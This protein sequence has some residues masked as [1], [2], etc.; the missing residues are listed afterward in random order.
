MKARSL[1]S[2][3]LLVVLIGSIFLGYRVF[4]MVMLLCA[5]LGYRELFY[6]KNSVFS[7]NNNSLTINEN[8][9]EQWIFTCGNEDKR[10]NIWKI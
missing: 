2:V 1:G 6:I 4:G 9:D 3:I 10:L 8:K 5:I 7:K